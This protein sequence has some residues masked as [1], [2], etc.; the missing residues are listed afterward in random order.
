MIS[1]PPY[2]QVALSAPAGE[3]EELKKVRDCCLAF[4]PVLNGS[5]FVTGSKEEWT[6]H[7]RLLKELNAALDALP[8]SGNTLSRQFFMD[9]RDHL[10]KVRNQPE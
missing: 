10:A 9:W 2:V 1:C 8:V 6:E 4:E 5:E 7:Q 3:N